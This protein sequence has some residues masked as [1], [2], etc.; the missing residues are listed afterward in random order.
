M[1]GGPKLSF[2]RRI[3]FPGRDS[4]RGCLVQSEQAGFNSFNEPRAFPL[5]IAPGRDDRPDPTRRER[6]HERVGVV[7]LVGDDGLGLDLIDQRHCL[8]DVGSLPGVIESATGLP[9][10][11]TTAWIFVVKL[12]TRVRGPVNGGRDRRRSDRRRCGRVMVRSCISEPQS[13]HT[14]SAH[15][16]SMASF[17]PQ[18]TASAAPVF[19]RMVA[20]VG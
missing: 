12:P 7:A 3:R 9:S 6:V 18:P 1:R 5:G 2:A 13:S 16:S 4:A 19:A 17:T 14:C 20:V 15:N 8:R 10:V 11:S